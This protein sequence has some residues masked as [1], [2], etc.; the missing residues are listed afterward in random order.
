MTT[1]WNYL[2][3][4]FIKSKHWT[5]HD[6][7]G[8][9]KRGII[10]QALSVFFITA[11]FLSVSPFFFPLCMKK[12]S[13]QIFHDDQ[14]VAGFFFRRGD[15]RLNTIKFT[16]LA[17]SFLIGYWYPSYPSQIT[18]WNPWFKVSICNRVLCNISMYKRVFLFIKL[19]SRGIKFMHIGADGIPW[20]WDHI[21]ETMIWR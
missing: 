1:D 17:Q 14:M 11:L 12:D 16:G 6:G 21:L 2:Q 4:D 10:S 18:L 19:D 8:V 13:S 7:S 3:R 5:R 20:G 15:K 9:C